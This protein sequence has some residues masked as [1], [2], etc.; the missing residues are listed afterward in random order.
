MAVVYERADWP[1]D[2][3]PLVAAIPELDPLTEETIAAKVTGH[4]LLVVARVEDR[5][6]GFK[7]GYT[8]GQET[9]DSWIGG[10]EPAFRQHGVARELLR[11]QERLVREM[12]LTKIIVKSMNRFPAMLRFLISEGYQLVAVETREGRESKIVFE[13]PLPPA[14]AQTTGEPSR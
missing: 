1:F 12:G 5:I 8:I 13:K 11:L 9:F 4:P 6:V 3:R 2:I 14:L 7:L 10:V